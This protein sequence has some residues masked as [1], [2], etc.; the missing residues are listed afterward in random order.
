MGDL[1][2][3]PHNQSAPPGADATP[4]SSP[5][6]HREPLTDEELAAVI[7]AEC[8]D[9]AS[10]VDM[11]IGPY[12]AEATRYYN[13]EPF[14]DEEEGQSQYVS[15]DVAEVVG[16]LMPDLMRIFFGQERIVEYQPVTMQDEPLA[17]QAT[18]YALHV[19][20]KDNP[21]YL[22]MQGT[23]KDALIRKTGVVKCWWD[24]SVKVQVDEVT[25][26]D[27]QSVA[28]LAEETAN[29]PDVEL[30]L[31]MEPEN[32]SIGGSIR[33]K[34]RLG[35]LRLKSLPLEEFLICRDATS[36][37]TARYCAHR[38]ILTVSD[39]VAM[40]VEYDLALENAGAT[41]ELQTQE[42]IARNPLV[43]YR[44]GACGGEEG[45]MSPVL[46]TEHYMLVDYDGDGV[47]ELRRVVTI[48]PGRTV[49]KNEPAD[50]RPFVIFQVDP[51]PH[52]V[53]G[54]SAADKVMDIQ[55]LKSSLVRRSLD[56]LAACIYP[57]LGVVD[58][59]VN[60]KDVLNTR[61]GMP[62]RMRQAG[63]VTPIVVPYV[64]KEAFSLVAYCDE[65][66]EDRTG[67]SKAAAGLDADALQSSTRAAVSAT[68]AGRNRMVELIARNLAETGMVPLFKLILRLLVRHQQKERLIRIRGQWVPMSP[69]GWNA[70]MDV[71]THVAIGA[72][73]ID[74]RKQFL[75]ELAQ[76]QSDLL[77][78]L[79]PG[80]PL[81]TFTQYRATLARLVELSGF[82]NPDEFFLPVMNEERAAQAVQQASQPDAQ[83]Q[84]TQ[85]LTQVQTEQIRADIA[86]KH[87]E[88]ELKREEMMR[89][90]GLETQ[91]L[92]QDARLKMAELQMKYKQAVE[93]ADIQQSSAGNPEGGAHW[94]T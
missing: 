27:E 37:E 61:I 63:A 38:T 45:A 73:T 19:I 4:E 16:S 29:D 34:S 74:E 89:K 62:I 56:S 51:E 64:G 8:D 94:T 21:G 23:F 48:G 55:Q 77:Q 32:G 87:A 13:R 39:L 3:F 5:I 14:G 68:V 18:E 66:K 82:A 93:V 43:L 26:L 10:Y 1:L 91:R 49:I 6:T 46:Y 92:E 86:V 75:K 7:G 22:V 36:V 40:G 83:T 35:R 24:D 17:R 67:V 59:Q 47:A 52:Q 85:A 72:G 9:A 81:V 15:A 78:R 69:A 50:E 71:T 57:R 31:H 58:D 53:F 60:M 76:T 30:D 54:N 84:A 42:A 11:E 79:G 12:R 33:R 90:F 28:L 70:D 80:N 44:P 2:Q 25:G 88:L 65:V 41:M 20:R